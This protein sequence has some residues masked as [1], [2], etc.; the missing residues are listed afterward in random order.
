MQ[1]GHV[2]GAARVGLVEQQADGE[3]QLPA[4]QPRSRLRELGHG[5]GLDLAVQAAAAG[6]DAEPQRRIRGEVG[7]GQQPGLLDVPANQEL[8]L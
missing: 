3:Q 6:D 5:R 1:P 7:D 4:L 8:S 2:G